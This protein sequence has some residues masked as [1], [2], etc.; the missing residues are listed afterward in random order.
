M[1]KLFSIS[2]VCLLLLSC[3]GNSSDPFAKCK[4]KQ[5]EAV[6]SN[7]LS[8]VNEHT[9]NI[10]GTT[11]HE[12]LTFENGIGLELFQSGCNEIV[13]DF[14][15]QIPGK[16]RVDEPQIWVKMAIDQLKY[17][18]DLSEKHQAMLIWAQMM[19]QAQSE[20]V[21]GQAYELQPSIFVKVDRILSNNQVLLT[22]ELSQRS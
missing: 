22:L 15:F 9:F 13:Q 19:E 21:T 6:F 10:E 16:F 7:S 14:R 18:G 3:G 11:G 20:I 17:M 12:R 8:N 1:M 4:Y 5:P 2:F